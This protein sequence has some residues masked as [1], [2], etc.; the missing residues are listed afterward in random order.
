MIIKIRSH[1]AYIEIFQQILYTVLGLKKKV[2]M[3]N[4]LNVILTNFCS[5]QNT[6]KVWKKCYISP[7][8]KHQTISRHSFSNLNTYAHIE[9]DETGGGVCLSVVH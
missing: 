2:F 1:V 3:G 9:P 8:L 4:N 7:E 5:L 6:I